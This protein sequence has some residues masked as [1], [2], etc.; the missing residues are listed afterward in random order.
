MAKRKETNDIWSL[1]GGRYFLTQPSI[2]MEKLENAV[3]SVHIDEY[4]RF[5]LKKKQDEFTFDYKLYGL[6]TKLVDR[7]LR[8]HEHTT[9]NVGVLLNGLKGTGKTVTS[10]VICNKLS[11]PVIVVGGKIDGV[12]MFINAIPQDITVF[13]DEYE[14]IFGD[15]SAM[16]TIMDGA[17][18]SQYRRVFLLTTNQLNV[19]DN[20]LQRPSRI[21]YLK[22]FEDLSPNIVE[23]IVDDVLVHKELKSECLNFISTLEVITVDIVKSVLSE[24]NI[25]AESPTV[26]QDVFNV[27]KIKGKYDVKVKDA[28]GQF[29]IFKEDQQLYRRPR[30][31]DRFIGE[32]FQVGDDYLGQITKIINYDTIEVSP[33]KGRDNNI[34]TEPTIF[35]CTDSDMKHY[36]YTYDNE[37]GTNDYGFGK[38]K[39]SS[40]RKPVGGTSVSDILKRLEIAN[41]EEEDEELSIEG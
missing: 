14:K 22:K 11:Q 30:F 20:L 28:D 25:H 23:E 32:W 38:A 13:I 9:G 18:N 40:E 27:K 1:S 4:G 21:R 29:V 24:V 5:Y 33:V 19:D 35:K 36:S 15:S 17:L 34:L 37:Y 7:I 12:H 8:T 10:K 31:T 3:Y 26:F 39:S 6:E 16:L 41:K 2:E